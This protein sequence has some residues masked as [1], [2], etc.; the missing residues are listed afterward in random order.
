VVDGVLQLERAYQ[1]K[2]FAQAWAMCDRVA[3]LAEEAG[4]HP[5]LLLE[6]GLLQIPSCRSS[7]LVFSLILFLR[8]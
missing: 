8:F 5:A 3:A 7:I 6:W 1:F 2:N 4:H